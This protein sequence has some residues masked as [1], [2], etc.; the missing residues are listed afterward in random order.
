VNGDVLHFTKSDHQRSIEALPWFLTGT[1]DGDETAAVEMHLQGCPT[2]R[3]ELELERRLR[4]AYIA[5]IEDPNHEAALTK[6]LPRL[7]PTAPSPPGW[8]LRF[9]SVLAGAGGPSPAAMG[10]VLTV[11]FAI[12][13]VLGWTLNSSETDSA[14]FHTL[15][16]ADAPLAQRGDLIVVFD[17]TASVGTVQRIMLA[18]GVRIINGPLASGGYVLTVPRRERAKALAFLRAQPTVSLVQPLE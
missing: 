16:S 2:C 9:M 12:A 11:Q 6:L 3:A 10:L 18:S 15:A 7:G 5:P 4:D 8:R 14:P 17:P 1:L 13:F